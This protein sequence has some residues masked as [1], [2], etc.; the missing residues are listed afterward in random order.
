M[1]NKTIGS[2]IAILR[3][4]KGLTQ[5][6]LADELNV[7]N[8]SVSRWERD[9]TLPDLTIVPALAELLGVTTDELL[10]GER[11]G[12]GER[13]VSVFKERKIE[14]QRILLTEKQKF[15][16]RVTILI[17]WLVAFLGYIAFLGVLIGLADD[18]KR[19]KYGP[20]GAVIAF[21]MQVISVMIAVIGGMK[22]KM[23][24]SDEIVTNEMQRQLNKTFA[25]FTYGYGW[26]FVSL[27]LLTMDELLRIR[28]WGGNRFIYF[29]SWQVLAI[30][31]I[32][33][34]LLM[35]K[36]VV[37]LE[38]GKFSPIDKERM[39]QNVIQLVVAFVPL[40]FLF[41]APTA[42][43]TNTP[44]HFYKNWFEYT[45]YG[46]GA[47]TLIFSILCLIWSIKTKKDLFLTIRNYVLTIPFYVLLFV[48]YHW[49]VLFFCLWIGFEIAERILKRRK[50]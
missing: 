36:I 41:L 32:V 37:R 33:G 45:L 30:T 16:Y 8:K 19:Y 21:G 34:L 44:S 3:K 18:Y 6:E 15:Q 26:F 40:L 42:H 25:W 43:Y 20:I 38:R 2:F 17:A 7:S 23:K 14:K 39:K 27:F 50:V 29:E 12:V 13:E 46:L 35:D 31:V 47:I 4:A 5:Q 11:N 22:F 49:L 1:E 24:R 48:S 28:S 10:R 9:E